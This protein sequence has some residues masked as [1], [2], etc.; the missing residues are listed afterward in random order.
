MTDGNDT[1]GFDRYLENI[2]KSSDE[3]DGLFVKWGAIAISILA[4]SGWSGVSFSRYMDVREFE[5]GRCPKCEYV[6]ECPEGD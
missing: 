3:S 4:I 1:T 2:S 5:A 6:H